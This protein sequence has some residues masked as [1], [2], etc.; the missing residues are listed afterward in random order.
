ML[1]TFRGTGVHGTAWTPNKIFWN[2]RGIS[3]K[4]DEFL[5]YVEAYKIVLELG[6]KT[7]LQPFVKQNCPNYLKCENSH[8]SQEIDQELSNPPSGITTHG[9]H[10]H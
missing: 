5:Y 3:N 7:H 4:R 9:N 10:S 8:V 6:N 1:E 2:A